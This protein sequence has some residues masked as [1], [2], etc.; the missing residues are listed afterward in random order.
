MSAVI[1][2]V[3]NSTLTLNGHIFTNFMAGDTIVLTPVNDYSSHI[4]ST[5]GGVNIQRRADYNVY[6]LQINLQRLSDDDIFMNTVLN[7]PAIEIIN[8]SW[9]INVNK[10]GVNTVDTYTLEFGSVITRPTY[11]TN[12]LEGNASSEY[13]IRFRNARRNV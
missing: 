7:A 3:E 2:D 4:V 8:G 1:S 11:T 13:V 10:D 6:N 12:V 5:A 9:K